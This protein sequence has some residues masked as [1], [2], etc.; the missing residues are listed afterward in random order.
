MVLNTLN[1]TS[2]RKT[3]KNK[4]GMLNLTYLGTGKNKHL[5][6]LKGNI[7]NVY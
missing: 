3:N 7:S 6:T 1:I 4:T 2:E 5:Q